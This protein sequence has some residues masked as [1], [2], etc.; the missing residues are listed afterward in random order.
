[1]FNV[2]TPESFSFDFEPMAIINF[3]I[4]VTIISLG[5]AIFR[6]KRWELVV[7]GVVGIV[8]L[9]FFGFTY[10]NLVGVAILISLFEYARHAGVEEIDQRTKINSWM[11]VRRSAPGVV[12][13]FFVLVSFAAYQSPVAKGIAEAGQL[14]SASGQ[15]VRSIVDSVVGSHIE[16]SGQEKENIITQVSNETLQQ[17]NNI[18]KPYFKYAP[19]LLAFGLF[20]ILWGLSWFFIQLSVLAGMLIF[21]I[22]KK[23]GTV[24]IE[25]R[26]VKAEVLV[27]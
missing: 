22:L 11:V 12:L 16:T 6:K 9:L 10:I 19:P 4:L 24:R 25:D 5:L 3:I 13:A 17:L 18:L 15:L 21:W 7:S 8:F 14:P 26:D 2:I 27:V 1:M 20:L 23:T